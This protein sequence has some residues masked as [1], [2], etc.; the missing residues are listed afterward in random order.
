MQNDGKAISDPYQ[1]GAAEDGAA[2]TPGAALS[3]PQP[4]EQMPGLSLASAMWSPVETQRAGVVASDSNPL[5][6]STNEN[7]P[8]S[9][10]A[11]PQV[12][13]TP[14]GTVTGFGSPGTMGM[15]MY[16]FDSDD[17]RWAAQPGSLSNWDGGMPD[18]FA[19]ATWE[20]LLHVVN[21]DNQAWDDAQG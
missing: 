12:N 9:N 20:S 8:Q 13:G 21:Q 19:A 18:V 7:Q 4:G 15:G 2:G 5:D 14:F 10:N 17:I 11:F 1:T 3:N 16:G 6:R